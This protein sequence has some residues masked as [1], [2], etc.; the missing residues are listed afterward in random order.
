MIVYLSMCASVYARVLSL[1]TALHNPLRGVR[2]LAAGL[3]AAP[4]GLCCK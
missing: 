1:R 4:F 3:Y 2:V